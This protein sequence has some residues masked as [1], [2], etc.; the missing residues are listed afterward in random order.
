[1]GKFIVLFDVLANT[2]SIDMEKIKHSIVLPLYRYLFVRKWLFELNKAVFT[3][4]LR[5]LGILNSENDSISGEKWF[6]KNIACLLD[7]SVVIDVGANVG[8]YSN[9]IKRYAPAADLYSFEPHP[10]TF[11]ALKDQSLENGYEAINVGCGSQSLKTSIYDYESAEDVGTSH[12]S[13]YEEV[14]NEVHLDKARSWP[15]EIIRL[16][17]FIEEKILGRIRLVKIDV[18]GGEMEVLKGMKNAISANKIDMI[19]FEFNEMNI[20]SRAFLKD[21][22]SLLDRYRFY[23]LLPDGIV[24]LG[25]YSALHWEIFA[26]Q[27]IIAIN[28]FSHSAMEECGINPSTLQKTRVL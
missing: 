7:N 20:F 17:D 9:K 28:Q 24:D 18:E 13:L 11:E 6:L 12:A 25:E 27:N 3:L 5:G 19:Q 14:I 15:I 4:S 16:D 8:D 21:I 26:Y 22:K 1:M 2:N 23:R 10:K